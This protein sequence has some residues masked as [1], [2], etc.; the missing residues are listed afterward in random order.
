MYLK[1]FKF[2]QIVNT[3]QKKEINKEYKLFYFIIK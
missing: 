3:E 2:N 1:Y